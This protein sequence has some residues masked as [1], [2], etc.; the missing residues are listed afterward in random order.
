MRKTLIGIA[1]V[2]LVTAP[3]LAQGN[4]KGGGSGHEQAGHN[5]GGGGGG[6]GMAAAAKA[7]GGNGRGNDQAGGE[8]ARGRQAP[9][10]AT[11]HA[12]PD[13]G[14]APDA[15][16]DRTDRAA[17]RGPSGNGSNGKAS[18]GNG[19]NGRADLDTARGDVRVA[20]RTYDWSDRSS[21]GGGTR[22]LIDGC[23]PGLAKKNNGCN[24]PGQVR[25]DSWLSTASQPRWW[26]YGDRDGQYVY[27]DGYLL[28]LLDGGQIGGFLPLLG[29]ALAVGNRW[30]DS[31]ASVNLPS[32]LSGFYG[33]E[34][35]GY[36]YADNA[37]Y[38]YDPQ[39]QAIT[40]IA[41]LLTGDDFAIGS[42]LPAGYD[43]Y[44][45]PYDWRSRYADGPDAQYRY[46]DGYIY[47]V[48]PKTQLIAAA[49]E[50]LAS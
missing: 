24:P 41:A 26:G 27:R 44:N 32:Y 1:A 21:Y 40:S 17:G 9:A 12:K 50:L 49:I 13:R 8:R 48:D 22:G 25:N 15:H 7:N 2:A 5:N 18:N 46:S 20:S 10:E 30:P 28:R 19:S 3:A 38:G 14:N 23:P 29:G 35:Q 4:G 47:Q 33:L 45:V 6:G 43:V 37:L 39:T 16:A 42:P 11:M 36:R 34:P 31:Y